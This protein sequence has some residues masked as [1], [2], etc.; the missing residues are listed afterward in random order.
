MDNVL[1]FTVVTA[2]GDNLTV[3][4]YENPDLFWALRGGGGG[5]YAVV[6]SVTYLTHDLFSLSMVSFSANFTTPTIAQTV[7]SK[8]VKIHPSLADQQW[9]GYSVLSPEGLRFFYVAPN[10][11]LADANLTFNPF[12][13]SARSQIP[14][15]EVEIVPFD[16]FYSFF[17]ALFTN[18]TQVGD[19]SELGSRL[20]PRDVMENNPS[21]VAE[22]MLAIDGGMGMV[23]VSIYFILRM[24]FERHQKFCCRRCCVQGRSRFYRFES[25]L[26]HVLG[27]RRVRCEL[28]RRL[29][30]IPNICS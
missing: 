17:I 22:S 24:S 7:T 10:V 29:V 8:W 16:S 25:G 12:I 9:G 15:L 2:S 14:D 3:N 30:C 19:A 11:S 18:G 21:Q 1:E 5:T 27:D 20:I 26:A 6:T 28:A 13:A 23:F 4:S